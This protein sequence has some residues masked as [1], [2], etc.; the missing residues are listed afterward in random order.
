M[1]GPLRAVGKRKGGISAEAR[2]R[3]PFA[4]VAGGI[5]APTCSKVAAHGVP[6]NRAEAALFD[7]TRRT[8][9]EAGC[10]REFHTNGAGAER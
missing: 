9:R 3:L 8:L 5:H 6:V 4:H 7:G 10:P 2:S 1:A